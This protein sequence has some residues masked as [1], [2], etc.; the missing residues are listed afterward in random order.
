[1]Q[2]TYEY[3][4]TLETIKRWKRLPDGDR[5]ILEEREVELHRARP[6]AAIALKSK[7]LL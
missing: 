1:L 4:V 3:D 5:I 7:H 2:V 6:G